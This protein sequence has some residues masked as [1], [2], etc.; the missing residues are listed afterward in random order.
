M[1]RIVLSSLAV[2]LAI[3]FSFCQTSIIPS[4]INSTGGPFNDPNSYYRIDWSVGEMTLVNILQSGDGLFVTTN[5]VLQ[6]FTNVVSNVN[7]T[8]SFGPGEVK[9]FPNPTSKYIDIGFYPQQQGR[10]WFRL[11][12]ALGRKVYDKNFLIY[13]LDR[14]ER[15]DVNK[16]PAGVYM[17]HV[18]LDPIMGLHIKKAAFRIVKTIK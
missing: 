17:L 11:Y 8:S 1:K 18:Q 10:V 9:V 4:V 7:N 15:I 6:S 2:F 3:S 16:F 14:I 5:G 13:G 12:D